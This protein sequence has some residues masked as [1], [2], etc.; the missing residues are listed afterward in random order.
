MD[1][2]EF[3]STSGTLIGTFIEKRIREETLIEEHDKRKFILCQESEFERAVYFY[4][5]A[6]LILLKD[7]PDEKNKA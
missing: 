6:I 1:K 4:G 5:P 3:Y 7:I 2:L